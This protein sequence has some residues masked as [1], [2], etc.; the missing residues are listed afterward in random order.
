MTTKQPESKPTT[1]NST[2]LQALRAQLQGA[3]LVPDDEG[4]T[5]ASQVWDAATFNQHPTLVVLPVISADVLAAV[6]FA[7]EHNLPI[8]VQGGGHGH[9]CPADGALLINFARMAEVQIFPK[10]A[11]AR[12]EAG[13]KAGTVVQAAYP[14]SLAPLNGFA[15]NVGIVG[16]LLGGGVGWLT[17]QYGAGAVSIRSAELVTADG[18]LLQVNENSHPDLFWGLRGGG[19]N[20]GVITALECALY[21]VKDVFGGQVTYPLTEGKNVLNTYLKWAKTIPDELTSALR[22]VH[23]PPRPN[24]PP[25]LRGASIIQVLACYNGKAKAGE[26]WL[27]PMRSLGTPL[28]DTFGPLPY[29][30]IATIANDP[31]EAPPLL[32]Y[33]ESAAFQDFSPNEIETLFETVSNPTSGLFMA[34]I[35]HVGGALARQPEDAMPFGL[36]QAAFYLGLLTMAPTPD[37]L[38]HGKGS[39][40]TLLQALKPGTTGELLTNLAGNASP[41]LTRAAYSPANYQRLVALKNKYDPQNVFR[42]NHNILPSA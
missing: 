29:S 42:F 21:P 15:P 6:T 5:A 30:Q 19:G 25:A 22:I 4:Y 9:P 41:E 35:R 23:F 1:I 37:L 11:S 18:R 39:I 3:A 36:Q 14:Y 32:S 28:L 8:A 16:Y 27:N 24:L 38:T 31:V 26:G 33:T 17:R 20:F 2:H 13:A 10:T 40:T 34:E 7:R 12:I